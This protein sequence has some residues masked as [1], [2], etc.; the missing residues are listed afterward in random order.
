[1]RA[2]IALGL[3]LTGAG[4]GAARLRSLLVALATALGT[5]LMLA[6]AAI[7]RAEQLENVSVYADN[8]GMQRLLLAV[9]LTVALPVLVLVATAARLSAELRDRRLANLRLL[10]LTPARTR[11]VAVTEAGVAALAGVLVGSLLFQAVRPVLAG[12]HVAGRTWTFA[13]LSPSSGDYLLVTASVVVAVV[14][15]AVLPQR[16]DVG[17]A[18]A[19]AHRVD[20]R[21]PSALRVL[22]L[23]VGALLCLF[24]MTRNAQSDHEPSGTV[25]AALFAGITL[26]G[27]GLVL[28]VPVLVRLLADALLRVARG[29]SGTVA[30][31]RL[32]AQ[33]VG[34]TRVV[35]GLL[36]GLFLVT[37][38]RA[39]VVAFETTPQ[40][41]QAARQVEEGQRVLL[42]TTQAKASSVADR[43]ESVAGVRRT[44]VLPRVTA[45]DGCRSGNGYC[46]QAV[47]ADC[48]QLHAIA[49]ALTGCRDGVPMWADADDMTLEQTRG[50]TL[51]WFAQHNYRA[52]RQAGAVA[53]TPA[54]TA[55]L[56]GEAWL[57]LDPVNA[58][59][60]LPP[61]LL[62]HGALPANAQVEV[63][64]LG[65]PGRS[66]AGDLEQAGLTATSYWGFEDYDFVAGLRAI[67][68]SVAAVVLS[69]G[70]LAFAVAA[71]DRAVAR[72]REVMSLQ[73][74]GVSRAVLR[75]S[76]WLEAGLP[77]GVGTLLAI[78]LGML[79]GATYLSLAE[80]LDTLPW[81]QSATLAAVS[82]LS[83]VVIAGLT[84]VAASPRIRPELI[85]AE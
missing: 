26:L 19:R 23:A 50:K 33:P 35:S 55:W 20:L 17:S 6:I 44:V 67:V 37:G 42:G 18:L 15:V 83:A 85:R 68:W 43:A 76:Q 39:V 58:M 13:A 16:L 47:V 28:V 41:V 60:V 31:R 24:V 73:L 80:E 70:L 45:G 61:S 4:G 46:L 12:V 56:H 51:S 40:Y 22:P 14:G 79:A 53:T 27:I 64:A 84:V 81:R 54:P 11:L 49:P 66:L 7:A 77:I 29:P 25:V 59:V 78:G 5:A 21:R 57:E 63:L 62:H 38:A 34:V 74:V 36:I 32:Q 75:R 48:A 82:F 72:R 9:V 8:T 71:V 10:G 2:A 52:L 1:M 65:D 69:V 3:R 30:G